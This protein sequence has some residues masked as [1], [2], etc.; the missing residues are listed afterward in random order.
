MAQRLFPIFRPRHERKCILLVRHGESTYN[1]MDA[2]S[3]SWGDPP[4][5]DAPL[6][7]RG[8]N[9]AH[10]L[11]EPLAKIIAK[12]AAELGTSEPL[13]LVSP[14]TRAIETFLG[15]CPSVADRLRAAHCGGGSNAGGTG[16]GGSEAGPS[17]SS[18]PLAGGGTSSL[19]NVVVLSLIAEH[20]AT[21]GDVG[22]PCSDLRR[23][24]PCLSHALRDLKEVWWYNPDPSERPNCHR[25]KRLGRPEPKDHMRQRLAEFTR[26]LHTRPERLVVAFGHSQFW[27]GFSNSQRSLKNC[28]FT[29]VWW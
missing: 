10:A 27:K 16:T 11:R 24:F 19:P 3:K 6:T 8:H 22:R 14:L 29:C 18:S 15:A 2:E 1:K 13:W 26:W 9:Q 25:R 20:C 21:S 23:V 5:F 4:V 7:Q 28:E 12:R 17:S